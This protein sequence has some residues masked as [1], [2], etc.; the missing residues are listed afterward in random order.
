MSDILE[1]QNNICWEKNL[2]Y[3]GR[4]ETVLV[5]GE[6]KTAPD[7]LSGRTNGGKLVNFKGDASLTG[8]YIPV[9]ITKAKAWSLEG[10]IV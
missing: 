1:V 4:I 7:I 3:E 9:K 2:E 5:D 6:S 8:Q 10:E